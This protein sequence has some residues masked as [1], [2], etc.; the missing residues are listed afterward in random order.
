MVLLFFFV[1]KLLIQG[2]RKVLNWEMQQ[3]VFAIIYV[4]KDKW[5]AQMLNIVTD[6]RVT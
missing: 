4:V 2:K 3:E 1:N 6:Y 5:I